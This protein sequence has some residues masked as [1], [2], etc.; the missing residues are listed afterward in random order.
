MYKLSDVT[1]QVTSK[2]AASL[3]GAY[4][5]SKNKAVR[6]VR[7][8]NEIFEAVTGQSLSHRDVSGYE[9]NR[10]KFEKECILSL[11]N[12]V[13]GI[14]AA[15]IIDRYKAALTS[16]GVDLDKLQPSIDKC[17]A[18][19]NVKETATANNGAP[20]P[21][22]EPKQEPKPQPQQETA[23][24]HVS[25]NG[26][27]TM[28]VKF[29][30]QD[31][32][33]YSVRNYF[34]NEEN[35]RE[36]EKMFEAL[37]ITANGGGGVTKVVIND[38][39]ISEV[40]GAKHRDFERALRFLKRHRKLLITGDTGSGKSYLAEQVAKAL[41]LDF[42]MLAVTAGMSETYITGQMLPTG[43]YLETDF[44]RLYENGGVFLLD[45]FDAA[46]SNTL[47]ILNNAIA[48]KRLSLPKRTG[49]TTAYMHKDFYIVVAGNTTGNGITGGF[50][51]REPQDKSFL[52]RFKMS[53]IASKY[54]VELE[55]A[56]LHQAPQL[57]EKLHNMRAQIERG[58]MAE[59][60][61][62]STRNMIDALKNHLDGDTW[63]EIFETI[64]LDW[65]P[66]ELAKVSA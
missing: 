59:E 43:E 45:E 12:A 13:S 47:L 27:W 18:A 65:E 7:T 8:F 66:E 1:K 26:V 21:Q 32:V 30:M 52:D 10:P 55:R 54:D 40:E 57:C 6:K 63:E 5:H 31:A 36:L 38:V 9:T 11:F 2:S 28:Q 23:A 34:T 60:R 37:N 51:G 61:N 25:A 39:E 42:E 22:Q 4:F 33:N 14:K 46:D 20:Q 41:N 17:E 35:H 3:A 16:D 44:V 62:I 48:N 64:T 24:Q 19:V 49:N 29:P 53:R 15:Q 58:G 50:N 56:L